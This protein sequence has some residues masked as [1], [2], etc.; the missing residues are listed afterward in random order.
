[1]TSLGPALDQTT[2]VAWTPDGR[3]V[4][5]G[6][7]SGEVR[8]WALADSRSVALPMPVAARPAAVALV[9]PALT[10]AQTFRPKPVAITSKGNQLD[11]VA[12]PR[13][14]LEAALA[15]AREAAA[16]AER[17]LAA[18]TKL[19]RS[20]AA[21]SD[22]PG[23]ATDALKSANVA[24]IALQAALAADPGNATLERA[25]TET[26]RAIK[27]L[28]GRG[29]LKSASAPEPESGRDGP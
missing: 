13:D 15:S 12:S 27:S 22:G 8:V 1:M 5:S 29:E 26:K 4:V 28:E 2:R 14:D 18:L 20:R 11:V 21:R 23:P 25:L 17:T 19:T 7:L 16:S 24:L 6:D 9:A 3:S 10:P